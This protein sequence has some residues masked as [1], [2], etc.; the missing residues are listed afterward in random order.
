MKKYQETDNFTDI[1]VKY[2][3]DFIMI[4]ICILKLNEIIFI[5]YEHSAWHMVALFFFLMNNLSY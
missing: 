4:C 2:K 1:K 5:K 3:L